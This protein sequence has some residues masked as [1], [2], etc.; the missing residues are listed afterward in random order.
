MPTAETNTDPQ[1][2]DGNDDLAV[3][4]QEISDLRTELTDHKQKIKM[5]KIQLEKSRKINKQRLRRINT[6][7][8]NI[9]RSGQTSTKLYNILYELLQR[10]KMKLLEGLAQALSD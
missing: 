9:S 2:I 10:E 8:K 1:M 4:Q 6:L 7:T 5:L 3:L